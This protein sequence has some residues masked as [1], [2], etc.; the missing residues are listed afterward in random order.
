M[1]SSRKGEFPPQVS[2]AVK[3]WPRWLLEVTASIAR[4]IATRAKRGTTHDDA[5]SA[6]T[7]FSGLP[8]S[9]IPDIVF[10]LPQNRQPGVRTQYVIG[11]I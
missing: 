9:G 11:D 2:L 4:R 1:N 8:F 10:P 6:K 7:P 5:R 3:I